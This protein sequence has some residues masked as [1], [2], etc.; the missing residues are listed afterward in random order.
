M[1][2]YMKAKFI[3]NTFLNSSCGFFSSEDEISTIYKRI[4][5]V[6]REKKKLKKWCRVLFPTDYTESFYLYIFKTQELAEER[7]GR[8]HSSLV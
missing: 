4:G 5:V 7:R 6:L 2:Y 8:R 3:Q 1:S